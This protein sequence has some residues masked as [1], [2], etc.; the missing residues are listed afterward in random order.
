MKTNYKMKPLFLFLFINLLSLVGFAQSAPATPAATEGAMPVNTILS[1]IALILLFI[2]IVLSMTVNSAIE[3]YKLNKQKAKDTT[4]KGVSVLIALL[5]ISQLS[6]AEEAATT[7]AVTTATNAASSA[8]N[9]YFWAFIIIIILEVAIILFFV[10]LLRF[11]TGIEQLQKEKQASVKQQTLWERLNSLKPIEEEGNMDT[12]HVYDGIRE[13]DNV[14]PPWFTIG[15]LASIVAAIV[16]LY[17]FNISG[18]IP[19]QEDEFAVEMRQ[20]QILQDSLLKLEGGAIDENSVKLLSGADVE[21]G[22]KVYAAQCAA[23]HGDKGQGGVG[24]NLTD[25]YWLHG[26]SIKD[27][28][29][30]IK[31]GYVDKGMKAW[32][33][34]FSPKQIAQISSYVKTLR[35]TNPPGA[36]E[37]QGDLYAEESASTAVADSTKTN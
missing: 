16:Y 21:A 10:K 9:I 17:Q 8:A 20:A 28:F 12:G 33:D 29:K 31:Y 25:D 36:K 11:L 6:F 24:P 13:L 23:C 26:G 3:L 30:T 15:F 32:K 5:C 37:K 2:I 1:I 4:I 14:T 35:G 7:T 22:H 19:R 18:D 34:D 27:V